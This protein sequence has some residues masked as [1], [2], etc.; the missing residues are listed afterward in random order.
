MEGQ[1]VRFRFSNHRSLR[2]EY[3]LSFVASASDQEDPR[4]LRPKGLDETVLPVCAMYGANASGK[5]NVIDALCFMQEA[6]LFSHRQWEPTEPI[7]R[8]PFAL[9]DMRSKPSTFIVDLVLAGV[10]YE[11][12][13]A[14]DDQVVREEWLRAWPNGRRQEWFSRDEQEFQFG[15]L[16]RGENKAIEALTR[17]NSLFLSAAAQNN[18]EQLTPVFEWFAT[19]MHSGDTRS[20]ATDS[21]WWKQFTAPRLAPAAKHLREQIRHLLRSADLGIEDFRVNEGDTDRGTRYRGAQ[22]QQLRFEHRAGSRTAWLELEDESTGTQ[23]LVAILP[24]LLPV[25]DRGGLLAID[26]LNAFHPMLALALLQMFQ[27]PEKNPRG[28]QLLFNTHDST[29]LGNLLSEEP[30]L[31]RDQVWLTEKNK[32][33][34]TE[35]CSLTD[36]T[37][38]N[39]ENLE[40][41]YLQGRY[42]AV[43][44][45]GAFGLGATRREGRA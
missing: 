24:V 44:F 2:D 22:Q 29:L 8:R 36:Y 45:L 34:A 17:P 15:R 12:G 38:R 3:E 16:L 9:G 21:S 43:P 25:L 4:L 11:Y 10:H 33:G 37:P 5:S 41:G 13:F 20:A 40:R 19:R 42:G 27:D 28:A 6:V 31:R 23:A 32:D 1:I 7:P 26:E 18:H 14:L 30:P 39:T 35:L